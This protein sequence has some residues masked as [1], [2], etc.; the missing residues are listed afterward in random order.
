MVWGMRVAVLV[1]LVVSAGPA[2]AEA[3]ITAFKSP[4][5]NITCVIS[6]G[7]GQSTF[8]Q[9]EVRSRG[10]GYSVRRHGRVSTYDVAAHDDLAHRRFVLG[11]GRSIRRG[12]FRCR[13]RESGMTCRSLASGHGFKV[14][15]EGARLF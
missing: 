2:V 7:G 11:Y 4:S 1:S 8:A 15:R 12:A 9:C 5:G 13:S 3:R 10:V 14:S 6:T